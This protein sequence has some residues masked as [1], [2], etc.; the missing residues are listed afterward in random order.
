MLKIGMLLPEKRM[1]GMAERIIKED[2][3]EEVYL[4]A[5][6]TVDAVNEA[7]TAIESG[8]HI[9]VA[10]G[11]QAKVIRQY[12]N[13]P[14]VEMRFHAQEIGLLIQKAKNMIK[15]VHICIGLIAFDNMLCDLSYMEKL[16]DI[17][18]KVIY[19]NR[20]EDADQILLRLSESEER[21]DIIIGGEETCSAAENMGYPTLYYQST[22]ESLREA[23]I[24][25]RNIASAAES[26]KMNTAQFETVL[27]TSFNGIIKVNADRK[28]I[29]INKLV[30][31]IIGRSGEEVVDRTLEEVFPEIDINLVQHVLQGERESCS[32][33]VSMRKKSWMVLIAP[34]QYD[35]KIT[36]AIISL[37]KIADT[38][39][40][41]RNSRNDILIH[42]FNA[43]TI[44]QDIKTEN[45]KME[46]VLSTAKSYALSENPVIIYG[47]AGTEGYLIA[48]AIHNNSD[49]KAG[50]YVS[51]DMHGIDQDKQVEILFRRNSSGEE[52]Q[53]GYS[54]AM[55]KANHGTLFVKGMEYLSLSAQQQILRTMLSRSVMRTDAQP[56]NL[57]DV[58]IIGSSKVNLKYLMEKGEFSE[59]LYY[60]IQGL[61]LEIPSLNE[62]PEDLRQIFE[63]NM[64]LYSEK[65]NRHLHITEGGYKKLQE[66][67]WNGNRIQI[68]T[69]C[70]RLVLSSDKRNI[71]EV[72]MQRIYNE[73][74]PATEWEHGERRLVVYQSPE[75]VE[76]SKYLAQYHGNRKLVAEKLG[77]STTTLWRKMKKYGIEA[78]YGKISE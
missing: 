26:E 61:S 77:I 38:A 4:R 50:P 9:L 58:R 42:G 18:L 71:D 48:E 19:L 33:S 29:V 28:I 70:E 57:L 62:R 2:K 44:F 37:Q 3:L 45:R 59:E 75:A 78:N 74:Y 67:K 56:L 69:Y 66:L 46:E 43:R 47:Q 27:D 23:L 72:Q 41:G 52:S 64:K 15:K 16:F 53:S 35:D 65:Y 30:E 7:R 8:V 63:Q 68:K 40:I 6:H 1:I 24:S 36:G 31:N 11:Y 39:T 5:I 73:L 21:P 14:L 32:T 51:I 55:L 49:R 34:I 22:E 76:L 60:L 25:A 13:I 17:K 12:T 20:I 54:G 10:R